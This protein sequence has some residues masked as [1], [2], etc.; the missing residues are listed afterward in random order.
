MSRADANRDALWLF[1]LVLVVPALAG[2][3]MDYE[4]AIRSWLQSP[5]AP[6]AMLAAVSLGLAAFVA[7]L[8]YGLYRPAGLQQGPRHD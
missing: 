1:I 3:A 8:L 2:L 5:A 4:V 6:W 7:V